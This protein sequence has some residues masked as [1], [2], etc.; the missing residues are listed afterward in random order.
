MSQQDLILGTTPDDDTGE[1]AWDVFHKIQVNFDDLYANKSNVGHTHSSTDVSDFQTSVT[2]NATVQQNIADIA[3]HETRIN[4][5]EQNINEYYITDSSVTMTTSDDFQTKA[6]LNLNL[7]STGTFLI[8]ITY[9][10]NHDSVTSDFESRLFYDDATMI[11]Q[12]HTEQAAS[13]SGS[14]MGTGTSQKLYN[15]RKFVQTITSGL[16]SLK[17]QYRTTLSGETSAIWD[18][19]LTVKQM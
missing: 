8:E 4:T 18:V 9:G 19:V 12:L 17:L 16:H 7:A 10:W 11:G 6:T 14:W 2:N 15:S 3:D 5:L 1:S 13:D